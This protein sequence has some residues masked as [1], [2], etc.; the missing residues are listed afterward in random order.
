MNRNAIV[1]GFILI[2]AG[3]ASFA[4][5]SD[6]RSST[7]EIRFGLADHGRSLDLA[8]RKDVRR[9]LALSFITLQKLAVKRGAP[10]PPPGRSLISLAVALQR[11]VEM[12]PNRQLPP[13]AQSQLQRQLARASSI[14]QSKID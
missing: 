1:I 2:V 11:L 12:T 14:V 5:V 10:V 6:L 13:A 4:D 9:N 7:R 3:S 8:Q